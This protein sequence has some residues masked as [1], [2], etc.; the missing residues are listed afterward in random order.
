MDLRKFPS[1]S[2]DIFELYRRLNM[3]F[4]VSDLVLYMSDFNISN[5]SSFVI[6]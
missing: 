2:R 3:D 5:P 4:K 6:K 1:D